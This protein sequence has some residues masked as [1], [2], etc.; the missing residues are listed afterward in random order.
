MY[1]KKLE[2]KIE[3]YLLATHITENA[4]FENACMTGNGAQILAIVDSEME[5]HNLYTNGSK[6]LR[7]DILRMLQGKSQVPAY[8]GQRVLMF[9]YNSRLSGTGLA[10]I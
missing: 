6:K 3:D 1:N 9:V 4:N 5:K 7:A 2:A 10:V 8:I